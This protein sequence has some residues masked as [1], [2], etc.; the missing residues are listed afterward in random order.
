M[1]LVAL[2]AWHRPHQLIPAALGTAD[3]F[4][5]LAGI[6]LT[7]ALADRLGLFGLLA[8]LVVRDRASGY[9]AAAEVLTFT[10][11]LSALV[12]LDVAVVVAMPVALRASRRNDLPVAWLAAAVPVTANAASFLLPTSNITTLL[13]LRRAPLSTGAYVAES[14][15]PWLLVTTLTIGALAAAIGRGSGGQTQAA[16]ADP[17]VGA[18]LDLAPMFLAASAIRALL[19]PGLVLHG[20][21]ADQLATG[22]ALASVLNNLPVAAAMRAVGSSGQWGA[23]LAMAVGP[24]LLITGSVA[25]LICRRIARDSGAGLSAWR[26]S[27]IGVALLPAQLAVA[28]VGLR[29]AGALR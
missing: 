3:P 25:T 24:N 7:A 19:G 12:N 18:V 14:W 22:S 9:A 2:A 27:A 20:A 13:V 21:F 29:F 26:F 23:I 5:T 15:L 8:G 16:I 17:S 4:L 11:L 28:A 6:I 10:A 1:A